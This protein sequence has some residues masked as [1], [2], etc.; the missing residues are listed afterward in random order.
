VAGFDCLYWNSTR[1]VHYYLLE[2][3]QVDWDLVAYI[4]HSMNY[5]GLICS[6][7]R[8]TVPDRAAVAER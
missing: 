4:L 6:V 1:W 5:L 8:Q 2:F 3:G 7:Y